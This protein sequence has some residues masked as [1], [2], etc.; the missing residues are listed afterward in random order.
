MYS[1]LSGKLIKIV[2]STVVLDVNGIGYEVSVPSRILPHLPVLYETLTLY[3]YFHVRE[4]AQILYGFQ[5]EEEKEIFKI[6]LGVNGIGPKSALAILGGMGLKDLKNSIQNEDEKLLATIPGIG[7][8]T[9]SRIIL[10]LKDKIQNVRLPQGMDGD[11]VSNERADLMRDALMAL[12]SLGF[13][14]PKA[15]EAVEK[16]MRTDKR[17]KIEELIRD[18]IKILNNSA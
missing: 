17:D 8:K 10:E 1:Y 16:V 9:A 15:K 5:Y 4:D 7:K 6:L 12:I 18:S 2:D 13:T 14:R 3:T 11:S